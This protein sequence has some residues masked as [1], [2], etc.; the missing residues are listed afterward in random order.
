MAVEDLVN[1]LLAAE[2]VGAR[3]DYR[4]FAD[5]YDGRHQL[6]F[7]TEKFTTD[8][9]NL[10]LGLR[11]NLCP[12][13]V[14]SFT[15]DLVVKSWGDDATYQGQKLDKDTQN[16]LSRLIGLMTQE[17]WRSG[18][19]YAMV[20][21]NRAGVPVAHYQTGEESIPVT[22]PEDPSQLLSYAKR[23]IDAKTG[24]G[25]AFV[26]FHDHAERWVTG[27]QLQTKEA[28]NPHPFP[29][30]PTQWSPYTGDGDEAV[31]THT[32]GMVPVVWLPLDQ[33]R[34]GGYGRSILTDVVPIQDALNKSVANMVVLEEDYAEPF[35]YLLKY[36]KEATTTTANPY[37]AQI[38][39]IPP[40]PGVPQQVGLSAAPAARAQDDRFDRRRQHVFTTSA[41]GPA[42][43]FDPPDMEKLW[44]VQDKY[45][46]KISRVVGLPSFYMTQTS[47][48]VPSGE[49][50]RVLSTR[51]TGRL[52]RYQ[53]GA[54]PELRK[55]GLLLGMENPTPEWEAVVKVDENE[56]W[57]I[58]GQQDDMGLATVDILEYAGVANA[59]DIADR[60][61]KARDS[62]IGAALRGATS[63]LTGA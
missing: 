59:S 21:P 29:T 16:G 20:W 28:K 24:H 26:L 1:A 42:G 27:N 35:W 40:P 3:P 12:A 34:P 46:L 60:A 54:L 50:L 32:F 63:G 18:D 53:A 9:A 45:A 19:G 39:S 37:V 30:D 6:K 43:Q 48:D 8:Y 13:V 33:A 62:Q 2:A 55:L 14:F 23:W 41:E 22:D 51:R 57:Q 56:R 11:E 10:V 58:A 44:T 36:R 47:G 17:S 7:A 61:T 25:R 49:S 52:R 5:Y 15:D 31:I 4:L 38:P